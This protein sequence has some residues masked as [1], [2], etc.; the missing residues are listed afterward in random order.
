MRHT[1]AGL[2]T[3][4]VTLGKLLNLSESPLDPCLKMGISY[5][6]FGCRLSI[7]LEKIRIIGLDWMVGEGLEDDGKFK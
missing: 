2:A 1:P 3:E 5:Y 7:L 6:W 4:C